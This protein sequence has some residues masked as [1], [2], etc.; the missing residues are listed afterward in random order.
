MGTVWRRQQQSLLG[1]SHYELSYLIVLVS[2]DVWCCDHRF[3]RLALSG[4]VCH[5][6]KKRCANSPVKQSDQRK[7]ARKQVCQEKKPVDGS[8]HGI[9]EVHASTW[10]QHQHHLFKLIKPRC[11]HVFGWIAVNGWGGIGGEELKPVDGMTGLCPGRRMRKR[12]RKRCLSKNAGVQTDE[13]E[14]FSAF[15]DTA[16]YRQPGWKL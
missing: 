12:R 9:A 5:Q 3:R 4:C 2:S 1:P 15:A 8:H 14:V 13:H 7:W 6:I 10:H 11:L 16:A